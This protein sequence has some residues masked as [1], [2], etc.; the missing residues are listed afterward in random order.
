LIGDI[1]RAYD[2]F[3]EQRQALRPIRK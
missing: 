1:V 3:D 2:K